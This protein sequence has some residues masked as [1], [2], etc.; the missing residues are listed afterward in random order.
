MLGF[1]FL[2]ADDSDL[3]SIR[4]LR[5]KRVPPSGERMTLSWLDDRANRAGAAGR[6]AREE[7][8]DLILVQRRTFAFLSL[9]PYRTTKCCGLSP[10]KD[11]KPLRVSP[12]FHGLERSSDSSEIP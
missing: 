3:G 2:G 4:V 7:I 11:A 5:M 1:A 12:F 10:M 6:R 8:D 9:C